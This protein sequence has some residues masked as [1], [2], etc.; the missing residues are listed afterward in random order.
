LIIFL[1]HFHSC[2]LL[3]TK[4]AGIQFIKVGNWTKR[5]RFIFSLRICAQPAERFYFIGKVVELSYEI[6]IALPSGITPEPAMP[7]FI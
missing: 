7:F 6:K 2:V 3:Y 4:T 5:E 1:H